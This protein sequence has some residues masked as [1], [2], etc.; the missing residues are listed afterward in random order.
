MAIDSQI[1]TI[2]NYSVNPPEYSVCDSG[3]VATDC[4][5][6]VIVVTACDVPTTNG[7]EA[8]IGTEEVGLLLASIS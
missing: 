7:S 2:S 4:E 6:S 3:R 1:T 8:F 5:P